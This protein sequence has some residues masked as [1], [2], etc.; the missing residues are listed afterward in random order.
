MNTAGAERARQS[1]RDWVEKTW[2]ALN[3]PSCLRSANE[4]DDADAYFA[5][6]DE[7]EVAGDLADLERLESQLS[8]L[9]AASGDN[10]QA[11]VEIMT[12]HKSKGLEFEVVI[13]PSL[14]RVGGRDSTKLLRWTR[15]TGL[16]ADGLVLAPPGAKGD[17]SDSV[18]QWLAELEK[19]RARYESQRL[20]Y[21]AVTRAKRELHLFGSASL[22]KEG[23]APQPPRSGTLLALLWPQVETE[24]LR[25]VVQRAPVLTGSKSSTTASMRR[26]P[27][28]W[29]PPAPDPALLGKRSNSVINAE[30]Q[31]E[32]DWVGETSRHIGTVVHAELEHLVKLPPAQMQSWN[33]TARQPLLLLRLAELGV[34]E[35]LRTTACA[36]VTQAIEHTLGDAKGR[37]ILGLDTQHQDAASE[38]ALTGVINNA[39]INSIIDRSFV[40]DHGIRWIVD[41]KTSS[42]E[43]GGREAFLQSEV[44]RYRQQMD[45]YAK[46]MRAWKPQE[47][48]KTA[49]YFPLLGEW[50]EVS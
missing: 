15:L 19:Q 45:R 35:A 27:L 3:G 48:V 13:L 37:W 46:L 9:Y 6:L 8:S 43:G 26:L 2:L 20:L 36:R 29:T 40:D 47:P 32:F 39:V 28:N 30:E 12:I 49:L 10:A 1:L 24:F 42:H 17:D 21:V 11:R 23:D 44:E 16:D 50:R 38:I 18:Y 5:R 14:H 7:L 41:F 34:P 25:A 4:L 22:N 33:A 31:P